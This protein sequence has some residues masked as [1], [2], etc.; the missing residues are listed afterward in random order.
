[1][2]YTILQIGDPDLVTLNEPSIQQSHGSSALTL[3]AS[4]NS[5]R[6]GNIHNSSG[7]PQLHMNNQVMEIDLQKDHDVFCIDLEYLNEVSFFYAQS[8]FNVK[9]MNL[10]KVK[11]IFLYAAH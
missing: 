7:E 5:N 3:N 4:D 6:N 10:L 8:N 11:Q 9:I 2:D 1:M